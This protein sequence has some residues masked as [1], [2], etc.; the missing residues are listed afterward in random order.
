VPILSDRAAREVC[1]QLHAPGEA[2]FRSVN[3][4]NCASVGWS[5]RITVPIAGR[6][7]GRVHG[8][9]EFVDLKMEF[10]ASTR[11]R[12]GN[13]TFGAERLGLSDDW[14]GKIDLRIVPDEQVAAK[15]WCGSYFAAPIEILG[16]PVCPGGVP[17]DDARAAVEIRVVEE[18][19]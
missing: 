15:H 1:L 2:R 17:E 9:G 3:E 6:V 19:P 8:A 14:V 4:G 12:E 11:S 18:Q 13:W 5:S 16:V 7:F 10:A